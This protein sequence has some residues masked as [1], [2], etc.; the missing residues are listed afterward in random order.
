MIA[1]ASNSICRWTLIVIVMVVMVVTA[2]TTQIMI[3]VR[4][5]RMKMEWSNMHCNCCTYNDG[6][7][8]CCENNKMVVVT[9]VEIT[10]WWH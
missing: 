10:C 9:I 8:G 6:D 5:S 1:V 4:A 7:D 3:R 2:V